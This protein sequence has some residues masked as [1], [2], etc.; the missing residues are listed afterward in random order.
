MLPVLSIY[1][2]FPKTIFGKWFSYENYAAM[3]RFRS[4]FRYK[5]FL[6]IKGDLIMRVQELV[7][8]IN[9][10]KN[11]MLKAEQLQAV[12]RKALEVKEYISIK[13]KKALVNDIINECILYEDGVYKF[14][15]IEKYIC[16]TM[17]TIKTY[18][19]L[20][21]S[22]DIENDYDILCKEKLL[23][24]IIDL[25]KKEYDEVN[26]LLQM[27]TD[28]ILSQNAIEVQVGKFLDELLDK[29][30]N[31]TKAASDKIE[32]FD[33]TNLPINSEE[34]KKLLKFIDK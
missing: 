23:E 6:I 20:E 21:F 15:D 18:T 5:N 16:F 27:Q 7:E 17:N 10:N 26:I 14:N 33:F 25:F 2:I 9:N 28:Y 1:L 13:E 3:R 34:L 4:G 30:N 19:N 29:I 11:K 32:N 31:I 24:K 12:L 22:N 8:A